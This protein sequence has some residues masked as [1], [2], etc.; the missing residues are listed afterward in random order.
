VRELRGEARLVEEHR[1]EAALL[2]EVRQDALDGD[3]FLEAFDARALGDEDLG[4]T[5]RGEALED[6]VTLLL[7]GGLAHLAA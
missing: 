2:A 1:D 4:H 5:A 6:A 7:V 3:A